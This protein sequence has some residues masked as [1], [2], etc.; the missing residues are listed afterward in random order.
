[1]S[2]AGGSTQLGSPT[3]ATWGTEGRSEQQSEHLNLLPRAKYLFKPTRTDL[4]KSHGTNCSWFCSSLLSGYC[5]AM[6]FLFLQSEIQ[7]NP[8]E[9]AALCEHTE[10]RERSSG[11]LY[12][13]SSS[14]P[15]VPPSCAHPL[16]AHCARKHSA[17]SEITVLNHLIRS[18]KAG[19]PKSFGAR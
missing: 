11:S 9:S 4:Q 3:A 14:G 17:S 6:V 5:A 16:P 1:M 8:D 12:P 19:Y 18:I 10:C 2:R 15:A 7:E 13:C